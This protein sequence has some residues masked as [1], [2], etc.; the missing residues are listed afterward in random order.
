MA[1]KIGGITVDLRAEIAQFR[2]D[3]NA[4][5]GSVRGF[6]AD[7]SESL[8]SVAEFNKRI[9]EFLAIKEV[10]SFLKESARA[11]QE[12]AGQLAAFQKLAGVSSVQAAALAASAKL[13]GVEA[14]T[15]T[16]AMAKLGVV[17]EKNPQKFEELGIKIRGARG[18][19]LP[20]VQVMQN[21]LQGLDQFKAG[22]DRASAAGFLFGKTSQAWITELSKLAPL[23]K[24]ANFAETT[25]LVVGLGL[26]TTDA[27][28]QE[29]EWARTTGLL[30]L[31]FLG[32]QNQLGEALLPA[33]KSV[34]EAI[35]GYAKNGD[36]KRWAQEGANAVF[37]LTESLL[38]MADF[39]ASHNQL[40]GIPLAVAGGVA[41]LRGSTAGLAAFAAGWEMTGTGADAAAAKIHA[42]LA[43]IRADMES[44][45]QQIGKPL[46]TSGGDNPAEGGKSF[47]DT[48]AIDKAQKKFEELR[49][50]LL[51]AAASEKAALAVA[52][53]DAAAR[54]AAADAMQVQNAVLK[55]QNEAFALGTRATKEQTDAIARL[56]T[57]ELAYKNVAQDVAKATEELKKLRDNTDS[58]RDQV[59]VAQLNHGLTVQEIDDRRKLQTQLEAQL[60]IAKEQFPLTQAE[61]D[62]RTKAILE[63]NQTKDLLADINAANQTFAQTRTPFENYTA[64][65]EKL[66]QEFERGL[67]D[68]QT[69]SRAADQAQAT[70]T[71]VATNA[72]LLKNAAQ[73]TGQA[74]SSA[75]KS[76][77]QPGD[78]LIKT[79]QNLLKSLEDVALEALVLKPFER[80][81]GGAVQSPSGSSFLGSLFGGGGSAAVPGHDA[82]ASFIV[83]GRS[84]TDTNL[85]AF[86]ATRGERVTID[87]VGG[88]AQRFDIDSGAGRRQSSQPPTINMTV[89]ANDPN[90]FRASK[91]QIIGDLH[92][93]Q[94]GMGRYA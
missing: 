28:A 7:I 33:L 66:N 59:Q 45:R 6:A 46:Q 49:A 86:R 43:K 87:P 29:E 37:L 92:R 20:M 77:I 50:T 85:V 64:S 93:A 8:S 80:A 51:V 72:D 21:T 22:T 35:A 60:S 13:A 61:A 41:A 55:F 31:E 57:E 14:E 25:S 26:A 44:A 84:G 56:K 52:S 40:I 63:L 5:A 94:R 71:G 36:L 78:D 58:V 47:V 24:G 69:F 88:R 82:G 90:S 39:V 23:L 91:D 12:W 15:V 74:L 73:Q 68:Q 67:I 83:G 65:I 17:I 75:F 16:G 76:A 4:A 79:A 3:M 53:E 11:T 89:V 10:I 19:L 42:D 48:T 38:G 54:R 34:A 9:V 62:Q 27:K 18:E 1:S 81:L 30:K 70:F 32:F 2:A